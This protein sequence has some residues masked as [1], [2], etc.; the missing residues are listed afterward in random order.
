[1]AS[2][3]VGL[4][5]SAL[6]A[7]ANVDVINF[8]SGGYTTLELL[9]D[10]GASGSIDNAISEQPDLIVVALAGSNDLAIG[11]SNANFMSRLTQLRDTARAAGIPMFFVGTTPKD[12]SDE[13][14]FQLADWS[15][16]MNDSFDTCWVPANAT[17]SPCF[18]EVFGEL[19]NE[20]FGIKSQYVAADGF[21]HNDAGH[22]VIFQ[23]AVQ[24]IQPYMCTATECD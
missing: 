17:Y 6:S 8:A 5:E 12:L 2:S 4:L 19:A 11:V 22:Q 18:I 9:P 13:E 3:W 14:R 10:S 15:E 21:H 7:V 23:Q 24:I 20:D 16:Q 1:L